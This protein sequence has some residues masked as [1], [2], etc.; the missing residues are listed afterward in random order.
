[1]LRFDDRG[2][3]E[4][5][6]YI[7][8]FAIVLTGIAGIVFFGV[9]MLNDAKDRNNFQNVEQGLTVV[10]SD[11]KRVAVEKAPV[12]ASKIHVEGGTLAMNF[13]SASIRVDFDGHTYDNPT[14]D[15]T[16]YSDTGLKTLSIEN[17]GLW[18]SYG[19]PM[20]DV[21]ILPPR[22]F[23]SYA[24]NA[25]VINVIR[26]TGNDT[27][28]YSSGTANLVMEYAGNRVYTY[29]AAVPGDVT[30]TVN[31]AYPNAWFRFM[32]ESID[33]FPVTPIDVNE[34]RMKVSISG[35]SEVIISEHTINVGA[36][37]FTG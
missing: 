6:G 24:N 9:T 34:T 17:G 4:S 27:A 13:S 31:T 28:F 26:L 8:V 5:I 25:L 12:K 22:I 19:G 3:S 18:K 29:D 35:V 10:Q 32:D 33:G 23:S 21:G 30:I 20:N 14:G 37:Y 36:P 15:I 11:M 1:M 16:Y 7:L 2:V